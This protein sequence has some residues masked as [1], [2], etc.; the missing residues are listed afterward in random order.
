MIPIKEY[1]PVISIMTIVQ[2]KLIGAKSYPTVK[3]R[4]A[5]LSIRILKYDMIITDEF[6]NAL[7]KEEKPTGQFIARKSEPFK[8]R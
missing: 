6:F 5:E 8:L 3:K 1:P 4:L 7:M 2:D